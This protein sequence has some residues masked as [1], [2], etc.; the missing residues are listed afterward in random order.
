MARRAMRNRNIGGGTDNVVLEAHSGHLVPNDLSFVVKL[1]GNKDASAHW[2][3]SPGR[4]YDFAG[5]YVGEDGNYLISLNLV[6]TNEGSPAKSITLSLRGR[7]GVE[8]GFYGFNGNS[9]SRNVAEISLS[10]VHGSSKA[11]QANQRPA[12]RKNNRKLN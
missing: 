11:G 1:K 4:E 10:E 3:I 6:G 8:N 2:E 12:N 7:G 5:T 9:A